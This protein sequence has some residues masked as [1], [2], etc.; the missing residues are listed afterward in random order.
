V[1][2]NSE[3]ASDFRVVAR[4]L[5]QTPVRRQLTSAERGLLANI[6]SVAQTALDVGCGDGLIARSL[7]E[8]GLRVTGV[9]LSPEMIALAEE[10]S[11]AGLNVRFAVRDFMADAPHLGSLGTFDAVVCVNVVHHVPLDA[12]IARLCSLVAPGG[13][14]LIQDVVSRPSLRDLP[15]NAV[16]ALTRVVEHVLEPA[17][18]ARALRSAYEAHGRGEVYLTPREADLQFHRLLPDA[19]VQHHIAWRYSVVWVRLACRR[20]HSGPAHQR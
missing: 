20:G 8:R 17:S 7:A 11:P 14:L 3:I 12:A 2:T 19:Y 10:R 15:R 16:A 13:V 1:K 6:P 18:T 4:A 5:A 9:D